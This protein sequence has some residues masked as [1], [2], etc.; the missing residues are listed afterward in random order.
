MK[1]LIPEGRIELAEVH[2]RGGIIS[3]LQRLTSTKKMGQELKDRKISE[4]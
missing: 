2:S 1:R 3:D 4:V